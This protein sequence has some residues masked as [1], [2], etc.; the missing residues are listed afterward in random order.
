MMATGNLLLGSGVLMIAITFLAVRG[1]LE[2]RRHVA[3]LKQIP[4]RIHVNG[5][6]GKSSVVRL[7]AGAL[8]EAGTRTYGK[9]TGAKA[10]Q[11]LPDGTERPISRVYAPNIIEQT[12][13]V[14]QAAALG[15]KAL[16]IECMALQPE[17]QALSE[18]KLI[19][20]THGVI[21]SVTP[22]HLDI[23]GPGEAEV[24]AALAG[25]VP[26]NG[27]VYTVEQR[28]QAHLQ[29]AA[30]DRGSELKP[31]PA[32]MPE[33]LTDA[34]M[35]RFQH[36][37]HRDNVA[38]AL[39]VCADLGIDRATA[40]SGMWK[41]AC[42]SGATTVHTFSTGRGS[43]VFVNAFSANDHQSSQ[44]AWDKAIRE[45][46]SADKRLLLINCRADRPQRSALFGEQCAAWRQPDRYLVMGDESRVFQRTAV[47]S[48]IEAKQV[49]RI[50]K[51]APEALLVRLEKETAGNGVVVGIGNIAG[52]GMAFSDYLKQ[53]PHGEMC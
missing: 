37:E 35:K 7:I 50:G 32:A 46:Q 4:I 22:D 43:L 9:T 5:S 17:Y 34:E 28:Y 29:H 48:G 38:L 23:M 2:W 41:A 39:T 11:I 49:I 44:S 40:L 27:R 31:V 47:R 10:V 19:R 25:T 52:P 6:R 24:A 1:M 16:V 30:A 13:F 12:H 3:C 21:T 33:S 26:A 15:C 20:A 45:F 36:V 42:D 18:L 51:P 14:A 53:H 8:R